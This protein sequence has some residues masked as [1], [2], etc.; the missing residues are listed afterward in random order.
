MS[1]QQYFTL[2]AQARA[3]AAAR[4]TA[5]L[6]ACADNG[7]AIPDIA[8]LLSDLGTVGV[9]AAPAAAIVAK[10]SRVVQLRTWL[11]THEPTVAST[12]AAVA[13]LRRQ[14]DSE[15]DDWARK[16][17]LMQQVEDTERPILA[18]GGSRREHDL[19]AGELRKV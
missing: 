4:V 8:A 16:R 1:M 6:T 12:V 10:A 7:T 17:S 18:V 19:L 14:A 9:D 3:A 13:S 11:D 15:C 2:Q 5:T